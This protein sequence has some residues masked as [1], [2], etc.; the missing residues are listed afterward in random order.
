MIKKLPV[1]LED[2]KKRNTRHTKAN[3][4]VF[5]PNKREPFFIGRLLMNGAKNN[6]LRREPPSIIAVNRPICTEVPPASI[7]MAG[8]IVS[9][10]MKF[11]ANAR[12]KACHK[13]A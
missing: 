12:N 10:S 6:W 8:I 13:S 4:L 9:T 11:L 3:I 1:I 5:I 2:K 7:I